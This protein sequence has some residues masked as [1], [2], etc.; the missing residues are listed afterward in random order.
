MEKGGDDLDD[1]TPSNDFQ[2]QVAFLNLTMTV[3][4]RN[5]LGESRHVHS[6]CN[7]RYEI[8]DGNILSHY[9]NE[10]NQENVNGQK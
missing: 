5:Q 3:A 8:K 6:H 4:E 7:I 2:L 10:L 9:I 1:V